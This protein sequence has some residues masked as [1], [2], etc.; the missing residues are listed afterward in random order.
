MIT[1]MSLSLSQ[2]GDYF[3]L[4][5]SRA[6]CSHRVGT[7]FLLLD[8]Y[9]PGLVFSIR[10]PLRERSLPAEVYFLFDTRGQHS[11]TALVLADTSPV[12]VYLGF[13]PG[14]CMELHAHLWLWEDRVI[15]LN[16]L[17]VIKNSMVISP[18]VGSEL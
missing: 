14:S 8:G 6:G 17:Q 12:L 15:C 9:R 18:Q 1:Q 13:V 16:P 10:S 11:P 7:C 5:H 4:A 3:R 2:L